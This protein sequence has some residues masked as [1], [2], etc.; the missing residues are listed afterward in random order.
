MLAVAGGKGGCGKTTTTLA[1]A[2]ALARQRR[3]VLAVDAD[4]E[5]PDLHAMAGVERDPGLDAVGAESGTDPLAVAQ[6]AKTAGV[7]SGVAVLPAVREAGVGHRLATYAR[8]AG[9]AD[10]VLLD[11]PAGA[12]PDAAAPLRA[13]ERPRGR[14]S[15]QA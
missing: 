1:L 3:S 7:A 9:R 6:S 5:M 8:L 4:P 11:C 15:P 14:V 2:G 13:D 12:G 10:V